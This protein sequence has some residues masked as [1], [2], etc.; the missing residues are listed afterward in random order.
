[1]VSNLCLDDGFNPLYL[2][3]ACYARANALRTD[4]VATFPAANNIQAAGFSGY[5][6]SAV[7]ASRF[8]EDNTTGYHLLKTTTVA[9]S[10]QAYHT[11]Q[12]KSEITCIPARPYMRIGTTSHYAWIN[13]I[14]GSVYSNTGTITSVGPQMGDGY[15][16]VTVTGGI[17]IGDEINYCLAA[18]P[19]VPS[20]A[21]DGVSYF[22]VR[23]M[24][25]S[26][27]NVSALSSIAGQLVTL[28]QAVPANRLQVQ[29]Y[30]ASTLT[31]TPVNMSGVPGWQAKLYCN[32]ISN[33]MGVNIGGIVQPY[34]AIA[35]AKW[36]D[37][38]VSRPLLASDDLTG[39]IYYRPAS[40]VLAMYSGTVLPSA[41][42]PVGN[43]SVAANFNGAS[44][45]MMINGVQSGA[46]GNVGAGNPTSIWI[47]SN[48][49]GS[50][51]LFVGYID[52]VGLTTR[53]LTQ[54]E[55]MSLARWQGK[56]YL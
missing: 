20:Y 42:S 8:V 23:A 35:R 36:T 9:T 26:Q 15:W 1:M 22:D 12:I 37:I 6:G 44:S 21:G 18:D 49:S 55:S 52:E 38:S 41:Y 28:A 54:S 13:G 11:W 46:T 27:T 48:V 25:L 17:A 5:R 39:G 2:P 33:R 47:G 19:T 24:V 40:S 10:L 45:S 3:W 43:V 7:S 29:W 32:G 56:V 4:V 34:S 53:P 50:Q 31:Y 16:P 30:N 14:D 51:G